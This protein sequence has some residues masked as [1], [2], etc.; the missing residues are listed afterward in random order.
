M[1]QGKSLTARQQQIIDRAADLAHKANA[2]DPAATVEFFKNDYTA[3]ILSGEDIDKATLYFAI[4]SLGIVDE[5][6]EIT[7]LT[8]ETAL[9][10]VTSDND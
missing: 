7:G 3:A 4:A 1:T 6:Q 10:I 5:A 9:E 2:D 8:E